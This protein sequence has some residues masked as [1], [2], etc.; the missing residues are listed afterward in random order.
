MK[1]DFYFDPVCPWCWI[2]SRW[3]AEVAPK[4]PVEIRWRTFSLYVK[5]QGLDLPEDYW[6]VSGWGREAL[7]IAEAGRVWEGESFVGDLYT[8]LGAR[9]H[10]DQEYLPDLAECLQAIGRPADW[11]AAADDT[12]WDEAIGDSMADVL[13]LLGDDI[14][15]PAI[16]F[17]GKYGYFGPVISPAPTGEAALTLFDSFATLAAQPGI[18]ELKRERTV[19][20]VF[21]PR[22]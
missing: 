5:N 10:N 21:G 18:W 17:D 16:V 2:T 14:G 19:G 6:T 7:R 1:I 22:P 4:R 12:Q 13:G 15:V 3:L 11:A 20:P 9:V 8:E